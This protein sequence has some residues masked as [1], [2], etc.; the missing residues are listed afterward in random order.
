MEKSKV[1]LTGIVW[2]TDGESVDLPTEMVVEVDTDDDHEV[3]FDEAINVASDQT[4]WC[5]DIIEDNEV[6]Q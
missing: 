4:G 3:M 5:I 1:K 2:D 6:V